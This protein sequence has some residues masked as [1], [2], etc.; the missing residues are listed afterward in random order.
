[1]DKETKISICIAKIE[2]II[3]IS[4]DVNS[5]S[6]ED[7]FPKIYRQ[8]RIRNYINTVSEYSDIEFKSHFR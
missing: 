6:D 2:A 1:M 3:D 5:F 8:P 4:S 7:F